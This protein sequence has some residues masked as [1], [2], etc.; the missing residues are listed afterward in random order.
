MHH[1][2]RCAVLAALA[3]L[4]DGATAAAPS[5]P[6]ANTPRLRALDWSPFQAAIS[7]LPPR[8][9]ADLDILLEDSTIAEVQAA[10]KG[11]ALTAEEL[12]LHHLARIRRHDERLRT[13]LELNPAA[14]DEA[15]ASDAR[16]RAGT[17][18]G[19]LDGI[20]LS[21]KDNI[22]TAAPMHTT[23]GAEI[24][25]NHVAAQDAVLVRQLRA[26]GAVILGKANLSEFAG[27]VSFGKLEGGYSAVGGQTINPHGHYPTSGSSSGSAAGVAASLAMASVGSETSGSLISPGSFNGVVAMKPSRGLVDGAGVVPLVLGNDSAG[28]VARNVSDAAALL[29]AIDT[30]SVDYVAG[31]R[32]EALDGAT[33]GVL[34]PD[35]VANPDNTPLLQGASASL[36]ALGARLRPAAIVATPDWRG[37]D[38]F[39][40][41]LSAGIRFD[42]MAYV[43]ARV[44]RV[45][46]IEDLIAY[47]AANPVRRVPTGQRLFELL[48]PLSAGMSTADYVAHG[49]RMRQAA[50]DMLAAT[51]RQSGADVL[52][53]FESK[54]SDVYA[55]AGY[56]AITVPL[57]L[58]AKGRVIQPSGVPSVGMPVGITFIGK[59]GEDAKLL[60]H[61][62]AFEQATNLRMAPAVR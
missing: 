42:M 60:A 3:V 9:S 57:G 16:R 40:R 22:E 17:L 54:H 21:V 45:S 38:R 34:A 46:S 27:V 59:P 52:V 13:C 29:D 44:S 19:P 2:L 51:F 20:P 10:M 31:L 47:N 23:A 33:V 49:A 53:S 41:Y 7:R 11:G 25:L 4:A 24:L 12:T 55:T 14:L 18:L 5:G 50:A 48:A 62:F 43:A 15:R 36:T 39:L 8:R 26:G 61:A 1:A 30:T 6:V 37:Y 28:P 35:I 32:T 56:P 58:R